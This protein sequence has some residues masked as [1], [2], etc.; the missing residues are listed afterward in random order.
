MFFL[1]V[2][3]CGCLKN[4]IKIKVG[5]RA[6]SFIIIKTKKWVIKVLL[7]KRI[8]EINLMAIEDH[9][10]EIEDEESY[11]REE[12]DDFYWLIILYKKI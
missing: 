6:L 8:Y 9:D 10:I 12:R 2:K 5:K 3:R 1:N 4:I 7:N 11:E